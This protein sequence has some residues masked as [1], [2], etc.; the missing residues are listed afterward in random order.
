MKLRSDDH[1]A[2]RCSWADHDADRCSWDHE[3]QTFDGD[4][5]WLDFTG[6]LTGVIWEWCASDRALG[7]VPGSVPNWQLGYEKDGGTHFLWSAVVKFFW[8]VM[9][10][11]K[12]MMPSF[13]VRS[14][15][16]LTKVEL[17]SLPQNTLVSSTSAV[18]SHWTKPDHCWPLDFLSSAFSSP[19][20]KDL[21]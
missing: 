14:G 3:L 16:A 15:L 18:D 6:D 4:R 19:T 7:H 11:C 8:M 2:D 9:S 21:K 17:L 10:H 5:R 20:L 13:S 1:D 12:G